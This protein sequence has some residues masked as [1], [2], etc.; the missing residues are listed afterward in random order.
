MSSE[1]NEAANISSAA[2]PMLDLALSYAARGWPVFPAR[3]KEEVD[4]HTGEILAPKTPYPSNGLRGATLNERIIREWWTRT[5]DAMVAIPT[6]AKTGVFVLDLDRKPGIG[7]GHDW[8]YDME[9]EHGALPDTARATTMNGGTHIYFTYVDGIRNRG[10]L[11]VSVDVRGEG[12]YVVAPGSVAA[13]GRAYQWV[14]ESAVADA[15]QWLLDI[16]LPPARQHAPSDYTYTAGRNEPY[17]ERA[18]DSELTLLATCPPGGRGYQLNS[19]AYS[20]G[21]LVAA[22][23]ISRDYAEQELFRAAQACGVAQ[24]DGERETWAKIRRGLEA[25][26]RTPRQIPEPQVDNTRLVDVK[27][28][29]ANGLR[30]AEKAAGNIGADISAADIGTD[31]ESEK[32][33]Q[34][35]DFAQNAAPNNDTN[36]MIPG[37]STKDS[38]HDA[39]QPIHATPFTWID[40]ATLPRREFAYGTHYIR[41]YVSVTVSPGGLG[42][43]SNSIAEALSMVS[44]KALLGI[45]PPNRMRVWLFNSE[46]P[47]DEMERRIM[48]AWIHYKLKQDDLDGLYVDTG[49]EQE[50]IVAV[51]DKRAGVRYM[52]PV[53]EAVIANIR[54]HAIDVMIVDPFVSTHGVNENDNGAIDKVAKLWAHIADETNCAIDIVHHLRKVADR[55]ATVEDARGA[56]A[57]IGAARSVRVLNR[58]T[59]EQAATAGVAPDDR[60]SIF[61]IHQGK[62]NLTKMSSAQDWRRLV[63]VPLGNGRGLT[64]PQDHAGVVSEWKWPTAEEAAAEITQEQVA[65]ICSVLAG[66]A[67]KASQNVKSMWAGEAVAYVLGL[68]IEEKS[69]RSRCAALLKAW[70][71]DGTLAIVEE[72][73]PSSRHIAK[74]VRSA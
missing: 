48:A 58:M 70:I 56:V 14:D 32:C 60:T 73:D 36:P 8:L 5:P 59:E 9:A 74:I 61:N 3:A 66:G 7:D 62:A 53:I 54:R 38:S 69:A 47:R 18:L 39:D 68:D 24:A 30:R 50:L 51:E 12:G 31:I 22:G 28:M 23:A 21:Q 11:G 46:D 19:S 4:P 71:A 63:S 37:A 52:V 44:G 33:I 2:T 17:V 15:P 49:R 45:K 72:R 1:K 55:E 64:K 16:L 40:P 67:Y 26:M 25:G 27:R 41:K 65:N 34:T 57:L 43:T 29:I 35:S 10:G 42:K 13:D 6:G 20:L